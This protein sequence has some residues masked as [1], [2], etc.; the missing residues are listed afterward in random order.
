MKDGIKGIHEILKVTD[1]YTS[2]SSRIFVACVESRSLAKAIR[3]ALGYSQRKMAKQLLTYQC[4]LCWFET[5]QEYRNM[6]E[7]EEDRI[8]YNLKIEFDSALEKKLYSSYVTGWERRHLLLCDVIVR[9]LR[10]TDGRTSDHGALRKILNEIVS[11]L[12][13]SEAG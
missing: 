10:L 3:G 5:G 6:P 2:Y 4:Y 11:G 9:Y 7:G 8:M 12:N 13:E 1:D